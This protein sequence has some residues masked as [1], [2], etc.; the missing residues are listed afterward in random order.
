MM[1][2]D[3]LTL[4]SAKAIEYLIAL[5]FLLLFVPFWR[6][7]M[8]S[9]AF[10][11]ARAALPQRLAD[12]FDVPVRTYFHPG[13]AWARLEP[14]GLVTVGLDGFA[15]TLVGPLSGVRLPAPGVRLEQGEPAWTVAADAKTVPMLA[16]ITGVVVDVNPRALEA[17]ETITRDPYGEGWLVKLRA[18][19]AAAHLASLRADGDARRWLNSVCESLTTTLTPALG[20][21]YQDGGFPVDGI[22]RAAAGD[23][24]DRFARRFL[25]TEDVAPTDHTDAAVPATDAHRPRAHASSERRHS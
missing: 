21:V 7:A 23:D 13:H 5:A 16:P 8:G 14:D 25:L 22:A 12:W 9:P 1:P 20:R 18:P 2:H 4:S 17:P 10:A 11:P 19:R 15:G 24:W 3:I 6:Y